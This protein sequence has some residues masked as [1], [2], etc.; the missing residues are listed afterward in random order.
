M[1]L[2]NYLDVSAFTDAVYR[3]ILN[4]LSPLRREKAER[5]RAKAAAYLSAGAGY[6]LERVLR[7]AGL[8]VGEIEYGE[9]GK[10]YIEGLRFNLSHSG[11]VA[12]LAVA[13][14]EIGVDVQRIAPVKEALIRRACTEREQKYLECFSGGARVRE[15]FRLWT[16]K[17]SAGK[18]FGTGIVDPKEYEIDLAEESVAYNGNRTGLS[19]REYPLD[20]YCLTVCTEKPFEAALCSV[21]IGER[22]R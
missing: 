5:C 19:F 20:G 10:P 4:G 16:A 12:V 21:E 15:F 6:L 2:L 14:G 8:S 17:E 3:N 9:H 18:Y 7:Q 11:T 1:T 13:E 22:G